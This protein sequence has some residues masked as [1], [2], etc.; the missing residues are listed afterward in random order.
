M[1][2]DGTKK[3][4]QAP[5]LLGQPRV[6]KDLATAK[7]AEAVDLGKAVG[8]DE[9]RAEMER[10]LWGVLIDGVEVDLIDQD[11][12]SHAACEVANFPERGV[13]RQN[14]AGVM[15]IAD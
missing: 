12:P 13:R 2:G 14:A 5:H 6:G 1:R 4:V 3:V 9:F 15:Q 7:A 10:R 11:V 8:G